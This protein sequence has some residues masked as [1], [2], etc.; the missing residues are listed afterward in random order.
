MKPW[1]SLVLVGLSGCAAGCAAM[2]P[3]RS[4]ETVCPEYRSLTCLSRVECALDSA[5]GC[6]VCRCEAAGQGAL[7]KS[8]PPD[9]RE[10]VP[11]VPPGIPPGQVVPGR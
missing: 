3:L 11:L 4:S 8:P 5:R 9:Q 6:Q 1:W 7:D 10:S 2:R